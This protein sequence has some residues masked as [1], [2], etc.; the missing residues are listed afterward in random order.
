MKTQTEM[1]Q[2]AFYVLMFNFA[3][4]ADYPLRR[5]ALAAA[6]FLGEAMT[7]TPERSDG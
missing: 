7:D 1:V 2:G 6:R 3:S 4:L 5:Q